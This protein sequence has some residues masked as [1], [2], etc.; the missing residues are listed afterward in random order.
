MAQ[1][2]ILARVK[3]DVKKLVLGVFGIGAAFAAA[4]FLAAVWVVAAMT[5]PADPDP[6]PLI[7]QAVREMGELRSAS[8]TY[9][10]VDAI[11]TQQAPAAWIRWAPGAAEA[12]SLLT[13]NEAFLSWTATVEAGVDL[14]KARV[15][16]RGG[17]FVVM[18]PEPKIA[19]AQVR[20]ADLAGHRRALLWRD[21]DIA[22]TGLAQARRSAERAAARQGLG[23]EAAA[24]ARRT[25]TSLLRPLTNQPI[26]VEFFRDSAADSA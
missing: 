25:V 15:I 13:K 14:K 23:Q 4:A 5:R 3:D 8:R 16:R 12:A 6:S 20:H 18:L 9:S 22:L 19:E 10:S 2:W 21:E 1:T 26:L 24:S 17:A 11:R 7:L